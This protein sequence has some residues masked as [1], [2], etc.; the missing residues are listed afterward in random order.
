ME[1]PEAI[2]LML[3]IPES[4]WAKPGPPPLFGWSDLIDRLT[5]LGDQ[6]IASRAHDAKKVRFYPRPKIPAV[7]M[8]KQ[9]SESKR[10]D[11][12]EASRRRNAERRG[13]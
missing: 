7:V 3:K 8:R 9:Q 2:K 4:E 11:A 12:I 10:D 13:L 5:D 1:D 6:L